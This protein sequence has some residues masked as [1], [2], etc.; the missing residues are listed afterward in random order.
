MAQKPHHFEAIYLESH[1]FRHQGIFYCA[2]HG[3]WE[4]HF[5]GDV[6]GG[7]GGGKAPILN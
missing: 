6:G 2:I 4:F 1:I 7:G 3:T 5:P